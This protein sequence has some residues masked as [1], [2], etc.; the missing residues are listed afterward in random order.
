MGLLYS[1]LRIHLALMYRLFHLRAMLPPVFILLSPVQ[2]AAGSNPLA[3]TNDR[4]C[5]EIPYISGL[6]LI[7]TEGNWDNR[8][9]TDRLCEMVENMKERSHKQLFI[10]RTVYVSGISWGNQEMKY[11]FGLNV[12]F[13]S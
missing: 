12:R 2:E 7:R 9:T 3:P 11:T 5:S 6:W 13:R 4:L 1:I 10:P 8:P